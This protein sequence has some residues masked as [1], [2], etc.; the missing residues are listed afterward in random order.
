MYSRVTTGPETKIHCSWRWPTEIYPTNQPA[1][2]L[3]EDWRI[4]EPSDSKIWP[5]VLWDLE[6]RL[7][8]LARASSIFAVSQP[9][10][11]FNAI[12]TNRFFYHRRVIL[13]EQN[14]FSWCII[15]R[16]SRTSLRNRQEMTRTKITTAEISLRILYSSSVRLPNK[17]TTYL[18][19][20][21]DE[22]YPP[23]QCYLDCRCITGTE[24]DYQYLQER[25]RWIP[26]LMCI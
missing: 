23:P 2:F 10:R 9:L 16:L 12:G 26:V 7:T 19:H 8:V 1:S 20:V 14:I 5:R 18:K 13:I 17:S 6:R 15:I 3:R 11:R 21:S 24:Y 25:D 22:F 4:P